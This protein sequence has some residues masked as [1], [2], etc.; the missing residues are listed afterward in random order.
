MQSEV[1]KNNIKRGNFIRLLRKIHGWLG[2]W[3]ALLGLLFGISGF[4]LNHRAVLKIPVVKQEVS[5][6]Q[7]EVKQP[8]PADIKEFTALIKDT[9]D[10]RY[11]PV[12]DKRLAESKTQGNPK[13]RNVKFL[14]KEL[15]LPKSFQ[16]VFQLPQA[17]IQA[18]YIAGNKYATVR[19]EDTNTWGFITRMHMGINASIG[20]VLLADSI[21]GAMMMLS[22]TG[23]LLWTKM[24]GSRLVMV[25]LI[26]T[27]LIST[28]L[29]TMSMV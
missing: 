6:I 26:L 23:V 27:S 11:D 21:A 19:R 9:L 4:I 10:I 14:D 29:I 3:G 20:W 15:E 13:E 2:L 16:I 1:T 5:E 24:R 28:I 7:L 17:K 8:Y 22:I 12:K 18:E 25:G